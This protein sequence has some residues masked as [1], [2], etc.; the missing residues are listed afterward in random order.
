MNPPPR[1]DFAAPRPWIVV[2]VVLFVVTFALGFAVK[3]LPALATAQLPLDAELNGRHSAILDSAALAL[4]KL[5]QPVVVGVILVVV[6][7]V[8][9]I[10][11][12]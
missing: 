10:L 9:W 12:G 7:A 8:M 5:D 6:F 2:T 1:N 3:L 11:K 4:D